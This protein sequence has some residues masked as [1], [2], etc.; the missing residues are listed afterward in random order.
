MFS[1][2]YLKKGYTL[3]LPFD[4]HSSIFMALKLGVA[5]TGLALQLLLLIFPG[6][7][8]GILREFAKEIAQ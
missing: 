2:P 4:P 3:V 7:A 6:T 8:K 1:L 5:T